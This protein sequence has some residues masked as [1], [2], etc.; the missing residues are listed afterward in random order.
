MANITG[1]I[2]EVLFESSLD[3]IKD[4]TMLVDLVS[5]FEP[6]AGGMQNANNVVW[7][8]A[9]QQ[10]TILDGWD[11]TGQETGI[12]EETYP[13]ILGT[14]KN[15][16]VSVRADDMRDMEFWRRRGVRSGMQQ[17][18]ELNKTIAAAI[19]TQGSL[20]YKSS[21][22]SGYNFVAEA[23][24]LMNEQQRNET[25]RHF[26]LNDRDTL[27]FAGDLAARQ[28]LQGRPDET[29]RTGQIGANIASFDV[30]T[31]S[32]LPTL[33][34][35][36]DPAT[37]VTGNQSFAPEGGS[38]NTAT[39]Q[40]TNVDYR[41]ATI[42]VAA[43]AAYN[44]GDKVEIKNGGVAVQAVGASDK[45]A[46][47]QARTFTIVA[48]PTATSITVYPKPIAADDPGLST[49]QKAYA[50]INTRILNGATVNRINTAASYKTNLFFDADAVEVLSG[51]IP[52]ELMASFAGKKVISETMS[53][54]QKMYMVYDG[55]INDMTFR[56]RMFTWWGVTVRDPM[57]CGVALSV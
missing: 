33:A 34:G 11:L 15:D 7:R 13:A 26:V 25:K 4:Q 30:H 21:A 52:A 1:K 16:F 43:S 39:G 12:I 14:P 48:K 46:T 53:N 18:T 36:A 49:L 10:A 2:A 27:K 56:Y 37:T 17:A 19:A 29:W 23:Q 35:G 55:N 54:G 32:F 44:V 9:E 6:P 45:V 8:P 31:G 47:G 40:V 41:S 28:T 3:T 57:R 5:R 22:T 50:N 38:V 51:S 42:A 20:A 24:A